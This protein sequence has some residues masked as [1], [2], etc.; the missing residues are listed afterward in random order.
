MN[1]QMLNE[2]WQGCGGAPGGLRNREILHPFVGYYPLSTLYNH[3]EE[4]EE[5]GGEGE[6]EGKGEEEKKKTKMKTKTL[7]RAL[8]KSPS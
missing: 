3:K 4:R 7:L 2:D 5:E 1:Y 6:R 8:R